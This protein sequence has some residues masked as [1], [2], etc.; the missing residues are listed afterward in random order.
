MKARFYDVVIDGKSFE[1]LGDSGWNV[2]M[3][4]TAQ[5]LLNEEDRERLIRYVEENKYQN[6]ISLP[7]AVS[8]VKERIRKAKLFILSSNTEG[9]PN[10]LMEALALGIPCISTDCPCGGPK[11]LM[12]GKENGILVP[13]GNSEKMA[14]AMK[15]IL[16]DEALWKKYSKNAYE[17][18]NTLHPETVNRK[19]EEYLD[20]IMM[21]E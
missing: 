10:A 6:R 9:M 2:Q 8:D 12:E 1:D 13:V 4:K 19:W 20:S 7:G 3:S 11:V 17:I 21:G 15:T 16:Q 14:E 5:R 18:T